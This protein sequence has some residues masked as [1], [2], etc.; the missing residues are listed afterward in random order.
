MSVD[1]DVVCSGA[2]VFIPGEGLTC[3]ASPDGVISSEEEA[4]LPP[5]PSPPLGKPVNR[6]IE[7]VDG[8][9]AI[10][11]SVVAIVCIGICVTGS[12][13]GKGKAIL[14]KK[15]PKIVQKER[16]FN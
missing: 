7:F 3:N 15:L 4:A 2:K 16:N 10:V 11:L 12:K 13:G 1:S 14:V 8:I 9:V 5:P 6:E